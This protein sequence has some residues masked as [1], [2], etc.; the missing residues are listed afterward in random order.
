MQDLK[1]EIKNYISSNVKE[2]FDKITKNFNKKGYKMNVDYN[3]F[4]VELLPK[5]I[6][7]QT[8]SKISLTKSDE[9]T[10]QENFKI[11]FSSKLY[12]IAS[13]VQ[14]LVNQEAR[15]CY[16]EN[17]GI[18]LI[19]P[20]FNIDKLRTGDSTIIYTVEHK[21]SKEKFRFAVRGCVIPP[22]I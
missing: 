8:D 2:C 14:E 9:T 21:D 4:E 20:E 18:M 7:V 3:G 10:K 12:E 13:V 22:G 15:F 19:Y 17:L 11:S 5:R 6:I 1:Q 16:S